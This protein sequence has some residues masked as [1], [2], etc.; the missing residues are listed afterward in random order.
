V[1]DSIRNSSVS[2]LI[3]VLT[4]AAVCA[5]TS[6][7]VI[8]SNPPGAR[9]FIDGS[10]VGVTPYVMSD[11]KIVGSTTQVR[12][13]APGFQP[14]ST[15]ISRNE[16]FDVV[17]CIGGVFLLVPFLWIMGYK[18]DHMYELQP[19]QGGG[20]Y[21]QPQPTGGYPPPQGYPPPGGGGYPQQ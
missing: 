16:Q 4:L 14:Y 21:G 7:T 19:A 9:V 10:P 12:I 15:A 11:T 20:G 2:K 13:E 5:C 8:R 18:P 17:A 3:A 1:I 6:S